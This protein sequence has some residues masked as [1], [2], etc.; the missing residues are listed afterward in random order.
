LHKRI[1]RGLNIDE[2][3]SLKK[4]ERKNS[5]N[6]N[7]TKIEFK[8]ELLTLNQWAQ[9]F[10][11]HKSTI[12]LR[13]KFGLPL[14]QPTNS[15]STHINIKDVAALFDMSYIMLSRRLKSG[16]SLE[17]AVKF[18][19][20]KQSR[21][22]D[23]CNKHKVLDITLSG[24]YV[25]E[26]VK[27]GHIILSKSIGHNKCPQKHRVTPK[28]AESIKDWKILDATYLNGTKNRLMYC[29]C[30]HCHKKQT[31]WESNAYIKKCKYCK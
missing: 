25:L 9:K 21:I 13:H 30:K 27:C 31:M 2:S 12:R 3:L 6:K 16:Q 24:D 26:C 4:Y 7:A 28:F 14:D 17:E 20:N 10:N 5:Y 1:Q 11:C 18:K 23:I 15:D 22:G 19:P 8:G 29:E